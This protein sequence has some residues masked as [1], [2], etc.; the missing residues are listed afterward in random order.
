M[1]GSACYVGLLGCE[2]PGGRA[3]LSPAKFLFQSDC[4]VDPQGVYG[5]SL[6]EPGLKG[7]DMVGEVRAER[8]KFLY[9]FGYKLCLLVRSIRYKYVMWYGMAYGHPV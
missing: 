2:Y 8:P 7:L 6:A 3:T 5:P 1:T 4:V 9:R